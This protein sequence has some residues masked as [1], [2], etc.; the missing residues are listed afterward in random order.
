VSVKCS[1]RHMVKLEVVII[2]YNILWVKG[3]K[4]KLDQGEIRRVHIGQG[5]GQ[6]C[7]L[8]PILFNWYN[9]GSS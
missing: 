9:E 7:C 1:G 8:S 4:L 3:L 6:G 5:V 2:Q